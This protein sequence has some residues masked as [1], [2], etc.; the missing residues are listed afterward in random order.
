MRTIETSELDNYKE[1]LRYTEIESPQNID[2]YNLYLDNWKYDYIDC[3]SIAVEI[4]DIAEC[5]DDGGN[6]IIELSKY[7]SID[8]A[9]HGWNITP[10]KTTNEEEVM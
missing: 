8:G 4:C 7:N 3:V 9:I 1:G 5:G 2:I 6:Y 10:N